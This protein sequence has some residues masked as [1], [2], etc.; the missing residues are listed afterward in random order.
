MPTKNFFLSSLLTP[1]RSSQ[2]PFL[3]TARKRPLSE[4]TTC[5]SLNCTIPTHSPILDLSSGMTLNCTFSI[6]VS[7]IT[8]SSEPPCHLSC[9]TFIEDTNDTQHKVTCPAPQMYLC[10][11]SHRGPNGPVAC[12]PACFTNAQLDPDPVEHYP[13][14]TP[15]S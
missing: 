15:L 14:S 5:M 12:A 3:Y 11:R 13:C 1:T 9:I 6:P 2:Y 7:W 4:Y 8:R 10:D